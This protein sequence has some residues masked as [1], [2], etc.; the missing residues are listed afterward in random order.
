MKSVRVVNIEFRLP[1]QV[2]CWGI[3]IFPSAFRNEGS[4]TYLP[5]LGFGD[6]LMLSAS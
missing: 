6:I 3:P 4:G 1:E 5:P 2:R